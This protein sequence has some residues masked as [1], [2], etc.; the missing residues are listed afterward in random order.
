LKSIKKRFPPLTDVN[1]VEWESLDYNASEK[2]DSGGKAAGGGA[3]CRKQSFDV[4]LS[5]ASAG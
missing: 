2:D 1:F 4:I 3:V 5:P